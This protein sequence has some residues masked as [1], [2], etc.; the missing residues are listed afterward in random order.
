MNNPKKNV[1][2]VGG[3]MGSLSAA[4]YLNKKGFDVWSAIQSFILFPNKSLKPPLLNIVFSCIN[5]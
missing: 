1:C 3:G 2:I 4:I 5:L